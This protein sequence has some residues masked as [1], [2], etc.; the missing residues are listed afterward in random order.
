MGRNDR[1][2]DTWSD[3]TIARD[4]QKNLR[5]SS[6]AF[7]KA[8][9]EQQQQEKQEPEEGVLKGSRIMMVMK[10]PTVKV[11]TKK[12]MTIIANNLKRERS[13]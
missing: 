8:L 7:G 6:V 1:V 5:Q 12:R 2:F 11:K 4:I 13:P 10:I 3:A 9:Q